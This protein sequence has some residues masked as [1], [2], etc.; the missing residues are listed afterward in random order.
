MR[1]S[2]HLR[3]FV[4]EGLGPTG[5]A[6]KSETTTGGCVSHHRRQPKKG[7]GLFLRVPTF[8]R[9][10]SLSLRERATPSLGVSRALGGH[11]FRV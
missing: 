9:N 8:S 5:C 1:D 11:Y 6:E 4:T 2:L 7:S 10:L 3:P